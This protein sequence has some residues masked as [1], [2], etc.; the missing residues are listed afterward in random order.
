MLVKAILLVNAFCVSQ[1]YKWYNTSLDRRE[2]E[3]ERE[4][5]RGG[6]SVFATDYRL[7]PH[8]MT[9]YLAVA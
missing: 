5:E 6:G 8:P 9:A 2:R 7:I 3:R 4:R 1:P